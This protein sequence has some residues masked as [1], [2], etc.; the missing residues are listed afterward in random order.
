MLL[1]KG[2]RQADS[3]MIE[4]KKKW[5]KLVNVACTSMYV[6]TASIKYKQ[7]Q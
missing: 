4:R 7:R 6:K 5:K 1:L 3:G 2:R